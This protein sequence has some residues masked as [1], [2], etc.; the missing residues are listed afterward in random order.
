[1]MTIKSPVEISEP[2]TVIE[3]VEVDATHSPEDIAA[4]GRALRV[5]AVLEQWLDAIHVSRAQPHA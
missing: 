4:R 3:P 5:I 2:V 1:M